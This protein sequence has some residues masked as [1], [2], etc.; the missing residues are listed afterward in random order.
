MVTD[1]HQHPV[2]QRL[3]RELAACDRRREHLEELLRTY[4]GRELQARHLEPVNP[5]PA[6]VLAPAPGALLT[7]HFDAVRYRANRINHTREPVLRVLHL[8]DVWHCHDLRT[9]GPGRIAEDYDKPVPERRSAV[10]VFQTAH[11]IEV[12]R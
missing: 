1:I 3:R 5:H 11:P 2:V 7:I 9:T 6:G 12:I 10:G 8:D 4:L